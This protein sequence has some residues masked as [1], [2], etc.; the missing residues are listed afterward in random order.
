MSVSFLP[1]SARMSLGALAVSF[2]LAACGGGGGNPAADD[3]PAVVTP[4]PSTVSTG[5]VGLL[6]T[7]RPTDE[8]S[9][10]KLDV[11]EAIL[12]GDGGQ[13][14]LFRG[15]R[16]I[17]LLDLT[18]F[19]EPIVFGEVPAG[20]YDKLR[21]LIDN[22]ELVPNDGSPSIFPK[23]PANG[24]IDMLDPGGIA[25]FPGRTLLA[26]I[27]IEANKAIKI[28]GTGNGRK[29]Q[30]R[31]VVKASFLDGGLPEKL[32]RLE[33]VVA[34]IPVSPAGSFLLCDPV[35]AESCITIKTGEGTSLF[36]A[37]GL[38]TDFAALMEGDEVVV[39]GSYRHDDD[40]DGDSDSD[41]DS[42]SDSDSDFDADGDSDGNSDSDA[43][44]DSDSDSDM[45]SDGDTDS[46]TDSD[47]D[48]LR[49]DNDIELMAVVVEIGGNA[50]QVRGSV[51][52][53]PADGQFLLLS[54][55]NG[56]IVVELQD[57][58]RFYDSHGK[59]GPD[60]V[61]LG[62]DV[63]V[64]GVRPEKADEADPDVIRAAFVFVEDEDDEQL[65][66]TI[67]EPLDP[68]TRSFGLTPEDGM[69]TCVRVDDD[70]DILFVDAMNAEVT[71]GEFADLAVDQV[72]DLFGTTAMDSCFEANE[73]IVEVVEAVEPGT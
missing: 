5:T 65:R 45:D 59:T 61:V 7:D 32:A 12:I 37:D 50:E 42:D 57:A 4:P 34:E 31:P 11:V 28:T 9:A 26:E 72:V 10:I 63:E 33:G 51:V 21:L 17:D 3:G 69:D 54:D 71:R 18:N 67:T 6:L 8:F 43:D 25:V 27:D 36:D 60:A 20:V 14:T 47:T 55:G 15:A 39:I 16:Q 19:N 40:D 23:L 41:P 46:D 2:F 24:K 30:F 70:A 52:A 53:P 58:T 38:A 66:G 64:E 68:A 1:A 35:M 49:V 44:S 48:G 56:E 73:V 62:A 29:Y 13:Q 22:L